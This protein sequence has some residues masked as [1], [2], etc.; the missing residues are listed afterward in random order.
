M[1]ENW[2]EIVSILRPHF[3]K[4]STEDLYQRD[5]ENCFQLLGWKRFNKTMQTQYTL[6]IGNN[7][8]IRLD[9]LLSKNGYNVLPI[10]I[11]RP[12]NICNH[13]QELQLMSYMRMLRVNVG[14][15]IGEE[16][17]L[18]YDNPEDLLDSICVFSSKIDEKDSNGVEICNLLN[19]SN[20]EKDIL[21]TFCKD[22]YHRI[23]LVSKFREHILEYLSPDIGVKNIYSLIKNR[24]IEDGFESSIIDE[25]M[26]MI[27]LH[28]ELSTSLTDKTIQ[29]EMNTSVLS[30]NFLKKNNNTDESDSTTFK[31][32][33]NIKKQ[34][35]KLPFFDFAILNGR[36]HSEILPY[37]Y[38]NIRNIKNIIDKTFKV[39]DIKFS[40]F[41]E[42]GVYII[43]DIPIIV[44][45]ILNVEENSGIIRMKRCYFT[46]D[47]II[48]IS[49]ADSITT[50]KARLSSIINKVIKKNNNSDIE[51]F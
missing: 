7:N 35:I 42:S 41:I 6:P 45:I 33:D 44:A 36:K 13:R 46:H 19:Y 51:K 27:K 22:K 14:L 18:Y 34:T 15:Y 28:V 49:Y 12:S 26:Q 1:I 29:N 24:F 39:D 31:A 32:I 43:N 48:H 10:E 3:D 37:I 2:S 9:I 4:K 17:R 23:Q 11:K 38:E 8:N 5:I 20:F 40:D 30:K 16:L 25:G 47:E 50:A 21:E